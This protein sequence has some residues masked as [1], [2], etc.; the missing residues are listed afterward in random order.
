MS[1][2][3]ADPAYVTPWLFSVPVSVCIGSCENSRHNKAVLRVNIGQ[4]SEVI[5][6]DLV[7]LFVCF[8]DGE[9]RLGDQRCSA[10]F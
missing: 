4:M 2:S 1:H 9:F 10:S 5:F 7:Y 8:I 6:L 3:L